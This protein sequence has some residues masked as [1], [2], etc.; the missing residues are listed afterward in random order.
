MYATSRRG[1]AW[2]SYV[3]INLTNISLRTAPTFP[4][5][6]LSL[7]YSFVIMLYTIRELSSAGDAPDGRATTLMR[8]RAPIAKYNIYASPRT[9]LNVKRSSFIFN[10]N[11]SPRQATARQT[12]TACVYVIKSRRRRLIYAA[13]RCQPPWVRVLPF[14]SGDRGE[15][16]TRDRRYY[17]FARFTCADRPALP[18]V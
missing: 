2:R 13:R 17:L 11:W 16:S 8:N 6:S 18:N 3:L 9:A 1:R 14:I 15:L 10:D 4:S 12:T 5:L 7:Q